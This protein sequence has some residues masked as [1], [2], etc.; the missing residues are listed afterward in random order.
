MASSHL[1]GQNIS[2]GKIKTLSPEHLLHVLSGQRGGGADGETS[3]LSPPSHLLL[4]DM[5]D[6]SLYSKSRLKAALN[7]NFPALVVKRFRKRLGLAS[8]Q[9]L[10]FLE[11]EEASRRYSEWKLVGGRKSV[12]VF[13]E[14]MEST[15]SDAFAFLGVVSEGGGLLGVG[16]GETRGGE[17]SLLVW[18]VEGGYKAIIGQSKLHPDKYGGLF[19]EEGDEEGAG[20]MMMMPDSSLRKGY[21][22]KEEKFVVDGEKYN[23]GSGA[24][25][26]SLGRS[27]TISFQRNRD[28]S[29]DSAT[30]SSQTPASDI[31][32]STSAQNKNTRSLSVDIISRKES[33]SRKMGALKL[34]TKPIA[35]NPSLPTSENKSPLSTHSPNDMAAPPEPYSLITSQLL[36][37]SDMLPSSPAAPTLLKEIGV[38]HILNMAAEIPLNPKCEGQFTLKW[39]PVYDNTEVDMDDALQTAIAFIGKTIFSLVSIFISLSN[40][41]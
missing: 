31:A 16:G 23:G 1:V 12:V 30:T 41:F 35:L 6:Q 5:R 13:D 38:T 34:S 14:E 25:E 11:G 2:N 20:M 32:T 24:E 8:F 26:G 9:L 27:A 21:S 29:V 19:V 10:H 37:G 3:L 33:P 40:F 36:V 7:V 28:S 39:I 15:T 22:F 4:L 18:A 17:E